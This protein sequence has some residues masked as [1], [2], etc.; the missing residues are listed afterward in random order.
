VSMERL[1]ANARDLE[2]ELQWLARVLDT[3]FKL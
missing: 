3:R 2:L 1:R